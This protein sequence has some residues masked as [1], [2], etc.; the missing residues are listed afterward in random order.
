MAKKKDNA[1]DITDLTDEAEEISNGSALA[2]KQKKGGKKVKGAAAADDNGGGKGILSRFIRKKDGGSAGKSK[3]PKRR[4]LIIKL[5]VII[6]PILLVAAFI[7]EEFALWNYLGTRDIVAGFLVTVV[8]KLDPEYAKIEEQLQIR[9]DER[10]AGLDGRERELDR[11]EANLDRREGGLNTRDNTLGERSSELDARENDIKEREKALDLRDDQLN[12]RK[13]QLDNRE[14]QIN[15]AQERSAPA[16]LRDLSEEELADIVSV[17]T[18]YSR[19]A[20]ETAAG[21]MVELRDPNDVATILYYMSERNAGAI[22]AVMEPEFAAR[23]T[24]ILMNS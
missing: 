10:E 13:E 19:M 23:I 11:R 4:R 9:S 8:S 7:V 2:G 12:S 1:A 3:D 21:I 15:L 6:V 14:A 18:S 17:S 16:Y 22:L 24:E 20:P 5:V